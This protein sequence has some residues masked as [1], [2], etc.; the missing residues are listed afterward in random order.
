MTSTRQFP[1]RARSLV[2]AAMRLL[3]ALAALPFAACATQ[4]TET[5]VFL[6]IFADAPVASA[7][8]ID[9][10]VFAGPGGAKLASLH[11]TAAAQT[12]ASAPLGSVVILAGADGG[13][14]ALQVLHI[15][16]QRSSSGAVLSD[17][18]VDVALVA[19]RQVN[20]R[21]LLAHRGGSGDAG[22]SPDVGG[23]PETG[24]S[25][26][27][28]GSPDV[29]GARDTGPSPTDG[30]PPADAAV[31]RAGLLRNGD[32]CTTGAM[33]SS[34]FCADGVCCNNDCTTLCRAC[35]LSGSRGTCSVLPSGSQCTLAACDSSDRLVPARLCDT[36]GNCGAANPMSCGNYLCQNA[37]CPRSCN[38]NNDCAA[39]ARCIGNRCL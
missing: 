25:P 38:N 39:G 14:A 32:S 13:A 12:T 22:G 5:S 1:R 4:D 31:D 26:E 33:C 3:C 29:G 17:G 28:G 23:S 11:R 8:D 15:V 9:L 37:D 7:T 30:A 6:E 19:R 35:N 16:G 18:S 34:G 20:A 2:G 24:G 10:D 27:V 21:L 36:A